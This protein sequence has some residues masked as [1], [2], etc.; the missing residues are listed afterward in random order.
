MSGFTQKIDNAKA[1]FFLRGTSGTA[2]EVSN[3]IRQCLKAR[4]EDRIVRPVDLPAIYIR[5][6]QSMILLTK[7]EEQVYA[8][9]IAKHGYLKFHTKG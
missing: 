6:G 4:D 1:V 8:N 7:A 3:D 2:Y 5:I 9:H